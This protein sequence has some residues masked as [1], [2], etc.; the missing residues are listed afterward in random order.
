MHPGEHSVRLTVEHE[1]EGWRNVTTYAEQVEIHT[2]DEAPS[3]V[4]R[5]S[6][7][8]SNSHQE[9]QGCRQWL[10]DCRHHQHAQRAHQLFD[11]ACCW[12]QQ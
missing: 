5:I 1:V 3:L 7:H 6:C 12:L 9:C 4:R 8:T 10:P 2:I 11:L